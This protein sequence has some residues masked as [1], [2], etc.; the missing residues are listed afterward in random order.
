MK[1]NIPILMVFNKQDLNSAK[2]QSEIEEE[3]IQ[4]MQK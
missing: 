3:L 1:R 4:E 2:K